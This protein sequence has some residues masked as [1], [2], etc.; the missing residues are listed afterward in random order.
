MLRKSLLILAILLAVLLSGI[1]GGRMLLG[2]EE[3]EA[4]WKVVRAIEDIREGKNLDQAGLSVAKGAHLISGSADVNLLEAVLG[5]ARPCPL[6]DTSYHGIAM[7][8]RTNESEDMGFIVLKTVKSDTTKVL[9]HSVVFL[10]D[11]TQQ[12]KIVLWHAGTCPQ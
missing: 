7:A 2:Q 8:G 4:F 11:S 10:K 5:K 9:Y 1:P 12:F 3:H 6:A